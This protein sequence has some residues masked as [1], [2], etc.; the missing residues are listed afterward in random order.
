M[1]FPDE[2]FKTLWNEFQGQ[3]LAS[4]RDAATK[5][6]N[7]VAV[8]CLREQPSGRRRLIVVCI[9]GEHEIRKAEKAFDL[10]ETDSLEDWS[11]IPLIE[12]VGR[13]LVSG[14]YLSYFGQGKT[15]TRARSALVVIAAEPDSI[16]NLEALLGLD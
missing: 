5:E 2:F 1:Q 12:A 11:E 10:P 16:T 15:L 3:T 9:A 8:K 6:F 13:T 4:L 7:G 14:C